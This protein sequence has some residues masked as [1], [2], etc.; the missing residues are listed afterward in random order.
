MRFGSPASWNFIGGYT[1][2][3]SF[4]TAAFFGLGAYSG[5]LMQNAGAWVGVAWVGAAVIVAVFAALLGLAILRLISSQGPIVFMG[6]PLQGLKFKSMLPFRRDM[7]I[8]FQD[9][10]GSLS[11]R[12]SLA[13]IIK[14]HRWS[15]DRTQLRD[16][17]FLRWKD[18]D[19]SDGTPASAWQ[20]AGTRWKA[21]IP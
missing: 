21:L 11:P 20:K 2:Y 19:F 8:V 7:Q 4:S 9:P 6:K 12:M 10:Y 13:D 16:I 17:G 15:G 3:P 1:G 18:T 5:A 14:S